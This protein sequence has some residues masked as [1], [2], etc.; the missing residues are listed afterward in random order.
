MTRIPCGS[1]FV[2]AAIRKMRAELAFHFE[3]LRETPDGSGHVS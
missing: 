2:D 3:Q 1:G